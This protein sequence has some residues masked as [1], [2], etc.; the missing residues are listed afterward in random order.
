MGCRQA[1]TIHGRK[2]PDIHRHGE[3]EK[4][5]KKNLKKSRDDPLIKLTDSLYAAMKLN[6]SIFRKSYTYTKEED[7]MERILEIQG[8]TEAH[9]AKQCRINKL[10]HRFVGLAQDLGKAALQMDEAHDETI[11]QSRRLSNLLEN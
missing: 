11:R 4:S 1:T 2:P 10:S 9:D 7:R 5:K 6:N 8:A 3:A